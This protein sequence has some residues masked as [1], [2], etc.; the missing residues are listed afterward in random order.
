MDR[1]AGTSDRGP[2]EAVKQ[3][4]MKT[5]LDRV[6]SSARNVVLAAQAFL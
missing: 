2:G 5:P 4:V 6:V 1:A 3:E